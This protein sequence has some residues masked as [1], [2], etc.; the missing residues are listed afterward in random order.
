[1]AQRITLLPLPPP[2]PA[3]PLQAYAALSTL[4]LLVLPLPAAFGLAPGQSDASRC[5]ALLTWLQLTLLLALPT[6]LLLRQ[7]CARFRAWR[8]AASAGRRAAAERRFWPAARPLAWLCGQGEAWSRLPFAS[9][10]ACVALAAVTFEAAA[11]AA[12]ASEA[13][14]RR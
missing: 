13:S 6:A 12:A 1:M 4:T 5:V 10:Y 11:A 14:R 2:A 9:A 7:E 3:P 8:L